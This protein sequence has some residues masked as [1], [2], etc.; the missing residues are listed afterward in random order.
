MAAMK[1]P[2]LLKLFDDLQCEWGIQ[3]HQRNDIE[4]IFGFNNSWILIELIFH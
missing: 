2:A 4:T 1:I 3:S